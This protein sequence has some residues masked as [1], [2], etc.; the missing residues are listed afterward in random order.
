MF[1]WSLFFQV[2]PLALASIVT[3]TLFALQV[4]VVSGPKWKNR[5]LAVLVGTGVVFAVYFALI[6]GGMSQL[7]DANTGTRTWLENVIELVAGVVV[8]VVAV[9]FLRPHEAANQKMKAKVEGYATQASPWVFAGIAAYMTVTDFSTLAVLL[10][11][12]HDVTSDAVHVY[13]KAIVVAF[14]YACVMLPVVVPPALVH[15]GGK[16]MIERLHSV[17]EWLMD[18]Q[19]QVM[20]AVMAFIGVVLA[21]RGFQGAFQ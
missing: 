18:H 7:P 21:W 15:F 1:V 2:L 3:P 4:L 5:A 16:R 8:L 13:Y 10:P 14:L 11:A 17:Y 19:M 6:L 12:L 20:G 9:W